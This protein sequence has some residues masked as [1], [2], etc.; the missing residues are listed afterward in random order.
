MY[1]VLTLRICQTL[2]LDFLNFSDFLK[3]NKI[4]QYVLQMTNLIQKICFMFMVVN[5]HTI[6]NHRI[7]TS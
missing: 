6:L 3:K 7:K 2:L 1:Y 4:V 5:V